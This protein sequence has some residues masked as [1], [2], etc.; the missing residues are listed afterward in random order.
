MK[1]ENDKPVTTPLI[2]IVIPCY[3]AERYVGE[4]IRSALSQTYPNVEII[5]IDDGSTDGSLD[6]IRS[7]GGAIRWETGPNRGGCAARNREFRWP[8]ANWCSSWM[9]MTCSFRK[10]SSDKSKLHSRIRR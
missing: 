4:A 7:F 3:N 8:A 5:V 9:P 6:V 1:S 2:S 10:S